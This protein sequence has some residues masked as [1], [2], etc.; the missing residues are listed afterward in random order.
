M[1]D[2][3][4]ETVL[5]LVSQYVEPTP[6]GT[7][8]A[9]AASAV[10]PISNKGSGCVLLSYGPPGTG[11]T[12]TAESVAEKL[13]RP[14]WAVSLAE[15]HAHGD[16]GELES[17][18]RQI[19]EIAQWW[20]AIL[21]VDEADVF[22]ARRSAAAA[23]QTNAATGVFLRLLE[24][25]PGVLFLTTNRVC[26]FDDAFRSRVSLFLHYPPLSLHHREQVWTR[27][28]AR[29]GMPPAPGLA[30][31]H[32]FNGR[33]IR[34]IIT[35]AETLARSHGR[36]PTLEDVREVVEMTIDSGRLLREATR[37]GTAAEDQG[38]GAGLE[39]PVVPFMYS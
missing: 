25:F 10:D 31:L 28:L 5:R 22:L 23:F 38:F 32:A 13:R 30:A 11:K 7:A 37:A 24:Y 3:K 39:D 16:A 4:K 26:A 2:K 18:L 12:L 20:Q 6:S 19:F 1:T 29:A 21:L 33:E 36:G 15:L 35:V 27:L 34:N 14:L 9:A 17:R 8:G